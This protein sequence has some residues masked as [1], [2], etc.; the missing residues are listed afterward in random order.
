MIARF[1]KLAFGVF[2][3]ILIVAMVSRGAWDRGPFE[4]GGASSTETDATALA[5]LGVHTGATGNVHG[6]TGAD[7]SAAGGLTNALQR[8]DADSTNATDVTF[9]G[10][11]ADWDIIL[12]TTNRAYIKRIRFWVSTDNTNTFSEYMT[13]SVYDGSRTGWDQVFETLAVDVA[14]NEARPAM[15][16]VG[17]TNA[18]TA[19]TNVLLLADVSDFTT[20]HAFYV[21]GGTADVS[22]V[23]SVG[24]G[25]VT[26]DDDL[27]AAHQTTNWAS[28]VYEVLHTG[29][30]NLSASNGVPVSVVVGAAVTNCTI[31]GEVVWR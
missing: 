22:R 26:L 12:S 20:N 16:H 5:A 18:A 1:V 28:R 29:W 21:S 14:G 13:F 30:L 2:G 10:T 3:S 27:T 4:S 7:I 15:V 8:A 25:S 31:T 6:F 24:T 11:T 9:T 23:S 19:G 17:V